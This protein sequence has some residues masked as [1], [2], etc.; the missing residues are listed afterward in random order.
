MDVVHAFTDV[1]LDQGIAVNI[2]GTPDNPLFQANQIGDLLGL[3]NISDT[4]KDFDDGEKSAVSTTDAIGRLQNTNFLTEA[5]LYRLLFAS[6]K[7][8]ARPF[9]KWVIQVLKKIRLTGKYE[10]ERKLLAN[11]ALEVRR[12]M[13]T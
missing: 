3:C 2:Q 8:F 9:Q 7:P 4:I 1:A 12:Y 6:R 13:C 5:G 10:L 11:Q